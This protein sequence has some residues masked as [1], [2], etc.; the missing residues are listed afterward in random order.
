MA[1]KGGKTPVKTMKM[2]PLGG[3]GEI[4]K[5]MT[6]YEYDNE[7]VIVDCGMAFPNEDMPGVDLVLPDMT[8][9]YDN[10][11]KIK[12]VVITHGHEDHIG[13]VPYFVKAGID[14]P[15]FATR[16][17]AG[18]IELK[19][20]EHGVMSVATLQTIQA[21]NVVQ[22]GNFFS[23]EFIRVNHSIADAVGMAIT[24]PAGTILH[25]GDFKI[26][27][28]PITGSVIDLPR[29][30]ELGKEGLLALVSDST[31][32]ERK[33]ITMSERC[34]GA[35]FD[36]IFANH[37]KQRIILATFASNVDRVQ[38][39]INSAVKNGRKVA[40]S[41]RSMENV[42]EVAMALGYMKVPK[43]T[44]IDISEINNY[45]PGKIL[46]LTTGSQGEPMS[47]LN[48][49]AFSDHRSVEI[50]CNDLVVLS[51]SPIPGNEKTISRMID[52][53]MKKGAEVIYRSLDEVHV[54]GHACQE[55]L[56]LVLALAKPK[57][58]IPAHGEHRH[59]CI[60]AELAK[61]VGVDPERIFLLHNGDVLELNK[62]KGVVTGAVQ[63]GVTL[64]DG[65]GIG[66]IGNV[67][68]KERRHLSSDGILVVAVTLN[69]KKDIFV[70]DVEISSRGFVYM[71]ESDALFMEIKNIVIE[72]LADKK[73]M[74]NKDIEGKKQI[75]R[76]AVQSFV[77][78][79]TKRRPIV[80]PMIL[81]AQ[82][83]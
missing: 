25:M 6:V 51:A 27:A 50:N 72:T 18:L 47:A 62:D 5:N 80:V 70:S 10:R 2:I 7:I 12:G 79:Y 81:E 38:Q 83:V 45:K 37:T 61:T 73:K 15:I 48:R 16:M 63:S 26:D 54:S 64:V 8:Y 34:V 42:I 71:K 74:K 44:I 68:L 3:M 67:V 39:A 69:T 30:G 14:A 59:L 21:G 41:G 60:H 35:R 22:L 58:F 55:E 4:G 49:M 52:E 1:K 53:L 17:A 28:T 56:K 24:T 9:L 65:Y 82:N 32:A 43:G 29:I 20:R 46:L 66:D 11:D 13:A 31:N 57:Y 75:V 40:I 77:F 78:E 36:E 33:G 76:Q 23:V 19:L